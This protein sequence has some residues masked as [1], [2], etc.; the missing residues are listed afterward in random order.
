MQTSLDG[1]GHTTNGIIITYAITTRRYIILNSIWQQIK[2][3]FNNK[4]YGR[5][6]LNKINISNEIERNIIESVNWN[7][8]DNDN[9]YRWN[10]EWGNKVGS[11]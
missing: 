4:D 10:G 1:K 3:N 2:Y 9:N 7:S 5:N 6:T 8:K 11:G